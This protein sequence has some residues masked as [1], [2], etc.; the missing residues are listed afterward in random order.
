MTSNKVSQRPFFKYY[1]ICHFYLYVGIN[2]G[3][4]TKLS[5]HRYHCLDPKV[6]YITNCL[7]IHSGI[8]PYKY[9]GKYQ[10]KKSEVK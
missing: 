9:V 3:G 8:V 1:A 5:Y 6:S 2:V 10:G 7:I 4:I